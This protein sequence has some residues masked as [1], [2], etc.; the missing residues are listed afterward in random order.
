[1]PTI[2]GTI[3]STGSQAVSGRRAF[4]EVIDELARPV[5]ADDTT[6][7]ALA[8]DAF[9]AAVRTVNRRGLWPWEAVDEDITLTANSAFSTLNSVVK[10]PLAMHFLGAQGGT[11]NQ[12]IGYCPYPNFLERY[13]ADIYGRPD[14]YTIP[15][16]FETGQVRW[17]PVPSNTYY[18]RFA[19]YRVTPIPRTDS[20]TIEV[21]EYALELY[22]AYAWVEFLKRLPS[23]QRPFD[24]QIA[25]MDAASTFRQTSHHVASPGDRTREV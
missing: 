12:P 16:L 1:M 19:F 15:N 25:M 8:G 13:T 22:M 23:Q 24:I 10:K 9:R 3:V 20:E 17:F 21:P 11:I 18:A 5:D 6:V 7:R 14:T 4:S 2:A